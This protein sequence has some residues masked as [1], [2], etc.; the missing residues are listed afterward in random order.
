MKNSIAI[1][2]LLTA[3]KVQSHKH[4]SV[5][6]SQSLLETGKPDSSTR[7]LEAD[8]MELGLDALR[9][10]EEEAY[11]DESA[12]LSFTPKGCRAGIQRFERGKSNSEQTWTSA[13]GKGKKWEDP[14]F[15]ADDSS[16]SWGKFG[17][18]K[19]Y[20]APPDGLQWK[21]PS[22]MGQ[23]L[24]AKPSLFGKFGKPLPQG[25]AQGQL[26][27][28]WFLA[29]ASAVAEQPK[30]ILKVI[31]NQEYSPEGI[32]RF[33][34]WVRNKWVGVNID[35]RL[36]VR[37][38][39]SG[40][41]PWATW[42]SKSGEAWWMPLLEKAFAKLN[43]NYDRIIGGNGAEGLRTLTGMPT[44]FVKHKD[45]TP[46]TGLAIHKYWAMKNFPATASCCNRVAGGIDGLITG[47]AYSFLD[48]AELKDASGKV[49]NT[50]AK[51][52]NPWSK[53]AYKGP[54]RDDDPK[55]TEE[56]KK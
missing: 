2:A 46:T 32:F 28:C 56:W 12:G 5:R 17:F 16:L 35:D 48:V 15:G 1:S 51:V 34:F 37:S 7:N 14:E 8:F 38:W 47:H 45:L 22:E 43:Q 24:P 40:F 41:R 54:F 52:R 50:I 42:P 9:V 26:G 3:S 19:E 44:S 20:D 23:G 30:R 11:V 31:E 33:K 10:V 53:E 18:G 21:R 49:V 55:W 25:V 6:Y 4:H 27:D 39:G 29:S 13:S 36:P